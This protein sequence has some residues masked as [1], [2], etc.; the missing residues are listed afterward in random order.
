L[1]HPLNSE[2]SYGDI[3]FLISTIDSALL[4]K[5]DSISDDPE[6][7]ENLM[8]QGAMK[9]FHRIMLLDENEIT[10]NITPRFLFEVLLRTAL[11]E[12]ENRGYTIERSLS[13][14]VPVFDS[15][16]VVEFLHNREL[17]RY[18]ANM[19]ASFTRI[20]S[21]T[22]P[23]RVRKRIWRRVR[24]NDMDIDSDVGCQ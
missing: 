9:V 24:F 23:V 6:I 21:Y 8:E 10:T 5:I 14:K 7:I 15:R 4:T 1:S 3:Y 13:M 16:D 18:L 19:L 20:Q 17:I 12:L 22:I 2:L 11:V